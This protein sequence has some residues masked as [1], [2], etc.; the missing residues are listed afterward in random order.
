MSDAAYISTRRIG[1]ATIT[2]INEGVVQVPATAVFPDDEVAW[3]RANGEANASDLLTTC[4]AAILIQL[5]DAIV[6]IDPAFDDP[7][8]EYERRYGEY[9]ELFCQV[10]GRPAG[11]EAPGSTLLPYYKLRVAEQRAAIL[12]LDCAPPA[13]SRPLA[14]NSLR[15]R[16]G[17]R[18]AAIAGFETLA[19][20]PLRANG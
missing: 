14:V 3:L 4:Q 6:V 13:T 20:A 15:L 5:G 17:A 16:A 2:I 19:P 11:S 7:F 9:F 1:D 8:S 18:A 10:H 12:A